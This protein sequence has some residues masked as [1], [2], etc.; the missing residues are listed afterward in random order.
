MKAGR[1]G[2]RKVQE[3]TRALQGKRKLSEV[4]ELNNWGGKRGSGKETPR[5]SSQ[6]QEI[7]S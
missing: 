4:M 2:V 6:T 1:R 3:G 5:K 7:P